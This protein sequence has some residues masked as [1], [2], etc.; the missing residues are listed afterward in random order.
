V[1]YMCALLRRAG[2]LSATLSGLLETLY[3]LLGLL[4]RLSH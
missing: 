1:R 4:Q 3:R 2:D